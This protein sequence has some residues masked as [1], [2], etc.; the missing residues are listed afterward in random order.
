MMDFEIKDI[1]LKT[2]SG[3]L[4]ELKNYKGS[5]HHSEYGIGERC[6]IAF[7]LKSYGGLITKVYKAECEHYE[8][9][10]FVVFSEYSVWLIGRWC[11]HRKPDMFHAE[12]I[13]GH[14][15]YFA[16]FKSNQYDQQDYLK[17]IMIHVIERF[18]DAEYAQ[19]LELN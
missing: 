7:I 11:R 6:N 1:I 18:E 19:Q 15:D 5:A 12:R 3:K 2:D 14:A 10:A 17:N 8:D 4:V 16:D 9:K 13:P